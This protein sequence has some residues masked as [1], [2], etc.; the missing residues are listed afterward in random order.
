MRP[1]YP[2]SAIGG[3]VIDDN[4]PVRRIGLE[5]YRGEGFADV[6]FA[7]VNGNDNV[8]CGLCYVRPPSARS[9]SICP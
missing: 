9:P 2:F 4:D 3:A 5:I 8:Y 6:L 7:V 1:D